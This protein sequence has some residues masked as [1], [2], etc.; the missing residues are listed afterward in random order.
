MTVRAEEVAEE[1]DAHLLECPVVEVVAAAVSTRLHVRDQ[2]GRR[3]RQRMEG[4]VQLARLVEPPEKVV[5]AEPARR[6]P[7]PA[8]GEEDVATG[9]L[10]LFRDL[11]TRLATA[12]HQYGAGRKLR[13]VAVVLDVD[14]QE[15]G[16]KRGRSG[17]SMR[18][19]IR[20][21]AQDQ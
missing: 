12:D 7:R 10:Q 21:G 19:L 3:A 15:V 16:G 6:P 18:A 5:V 2:T 14:L 20:A 8:A 9:F 1:R 17:R 13:W 11:A 4:F